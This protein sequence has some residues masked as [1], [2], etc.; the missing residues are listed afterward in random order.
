MKQPP[1]RAGARDGNQI[2]ALKEGVDRLAQPPSG[3]SV[4]LNAAADDDT[5][6]VLTGG[7]KVRIN[8]SPNIDLSELRPGREIV[9]NNNTDSAGNSCGRRENYLVGGLIEQSPFRQLHV[10][11]GDSNML[12]PSLI[13]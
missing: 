9:L 7:R 5:A 6:D 13:D 3:F 10:I 2:I 12:G 11:V 8:V 4:F 1:R